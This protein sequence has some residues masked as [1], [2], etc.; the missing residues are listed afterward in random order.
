VLFPRLY[1][2]LFVSRT[3]PT[4]LMGGNGERHIDVEQGW[5]T[6]P[7][8]TRG[9]RKYFYKSKRLPNGR[10]GKVYCGG[11]DRGEQAA[12]ADATAKARRE[13]DRAEA[14]R[15]IEA[16]ESLDA[17]TAELNE[18]LTV[19]VKATFHVGG[20]YQHKGTWRVRRRGLDA[21]SIPNGD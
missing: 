9:R 15:A 12:K 17:L 3:L 7:W 2:D 1:V 10:V 16:F 5:Y 13:A 6:M 20:L 19:L 4:I 18:G 8:V 11:G 14:Q 21:P